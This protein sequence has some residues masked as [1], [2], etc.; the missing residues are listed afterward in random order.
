MAS[1]RDPHGGQDQGSGISARITDYTTFL[2]L[3]DHTVG[4]CNRGHKI[5][6]DIYPKKR[7]VK[8][9][10]VPFFANVD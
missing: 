1:P 3:P 2:T 5:L 10:F 9:V 4:I 6:V 7:V 8:I